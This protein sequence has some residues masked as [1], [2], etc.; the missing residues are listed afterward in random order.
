[1]P[2]DE[3][4]TKDQHG[5]LVVRSDNQL[6]MA[7]SVQRLD[8]FLDCCLVFHTFYIEQC[9][10]QIIT[11]GLILTTRNGVASVSEEPIRT[12]GMTRERC[13]AAT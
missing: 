13:S 7:K 4:F 10:L 5:L 9:M 11:L 6:W 8:R 2:A 3:E 1:M 12:S